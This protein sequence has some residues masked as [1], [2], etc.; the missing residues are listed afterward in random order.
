MPKYFYTARSPTGESKS[1]VQ[2]AKDEYQL[3][4]TLRQEGLILIRA[5]TKK[6]K[7]KFQIFF[8]SFGIPLSE[9]MFFTRN[10]EVMIS[11]GIPLPR[12]I[13]SLKEQA[14]NKKFKKALEKIGQEITKGTKFSDALSDFPNIFNEFYQNMVKV[15]EETGNLEEVLG[16]LAKQME[17]ENEMKSKIIGALIYPAVVI[18]AMVGIGV[19]M[20]IM[21][22]PKLA[23]TFKELEVELPMTTKIVIGLGEFLSQKWYLFFGVLIFLVLF[24]LQILKT[25]TGKK[26]FDNLSLKIP[27]ISGLIQKTNSASTAR[28]LS[29]LISGGVSLTRALEIT[30]NTLGNFFYKEALI[31]AVERVK[32]GEKL[33]L[34]L[35]SY[36]KIYPLTLIQMIEVGEET[37]ETSE[38]LSKLAEF[39]EEE[40]SNVTK[41]LVS[42]IEP[43]L[44]LFI[45]GVVGFFA[46]SMVQ[47]M[48]SM[49]GAIK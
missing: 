22:V 48:Y 10:L 43:V 49:L 18:L 28:N 44:M 33:S 32:K 40:V 2:E 36:Q 9:K 46:V 47:P 41:N 4:K 17:R 19:L 38:V 27:I 37:G 5:E 25:K 1:G 30:A 14:K 16:I 7:K 20:L 29:S 26:I 45:G 42:I 13:L 11:A 24:F 3:A 8:P 6:E 12:A 15:A 39:Y 31:S 21:V 34:A 23:E 35:K